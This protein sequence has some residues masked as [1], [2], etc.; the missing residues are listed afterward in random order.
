VGSGGQVLRSPRIR[1]TLRLA[2][3]PALLAD[4]IG[5]LKTEYFLDSGITDPQLTSDKLFAR[6]LFFAKQTG[7]SASYG[8]HPDDFA[9]IDYGAEGNKIAE[10]MLSLFWPFPD[11]DGTRSVGA[12]TSLYLDSDLG[13]VLRPVGTFE[14]S[15]VFE[16][17]QFDLKGTLEAEGLAISSDGVQ[18][19]SGSTGGISTRSGTSASMAPRSAHSRSIASGSDRSAGLR[20]TMPRMGELR[21]CRMSG[22][23]ATP[24]RARWK[25]IRAS[26]WSRTVPSRDSGVIRSLTGTTP[27]WASAL[28]THQ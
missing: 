16:R 26:G 22:E 25:I 6:L 19:P 21:S 1:Q 20:L 27:F 28:V 4:P 14:L 10:R 3:I 15:K 24:G 2:Q 23:L 12:G 7:A 17:W 11:A 9:I 13:L 18:L 8:V 5:T